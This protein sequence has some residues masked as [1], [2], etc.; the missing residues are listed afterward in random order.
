MLRLSSHF[1]LD[2]QARTTAW[3]GGDRQSTRFATC[4]QAK[5]EKEQLSAAYHRC[6]QEMEAGL[7]LKRP[8]SCSTGCLSGSVSCLA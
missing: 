7:K 8:A 5:Q 3:G 6:I 1:G 2:I 4:I